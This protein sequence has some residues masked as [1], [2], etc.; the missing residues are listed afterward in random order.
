[1]LLRQS[2]GDAMTHVSMGFQDQPEKSTDESVAP[3]IIDYESVALAMIADELQ[4][5]NNKNHSLKAVLAALR[6]GC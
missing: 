2:A 3:A 6:F 1:M 4:R 5:F